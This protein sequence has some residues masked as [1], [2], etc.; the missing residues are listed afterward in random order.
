[1]ISSLSDSIARLRS[2]TQ[3]SVQPLWHWCQADLSL[4]EARSGWMDWA[5]APLND[6]DHVAWARG[7][8]M[9]WL[10]Q[11]IIIPTTLQ[12][13]S[14]EGFELR[15]SLTWW[16]ESAR[17]FVDGELVQEGDL[18]DHS[19][20]VLLSRSVQPGEA[21]E[22]LIQLVSPGHDDGALVKALCVYE[23]VDEAGDFCPEPGFVADELAVL[24]EY[25]G[26]LLPERPLAGISKSAGELAE[27]VA[28]I[29]W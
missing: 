29:D 4:E 20:R 15:L 7:R 21:I 6:R 11:R 16:A 24:Q 19:A 25:V 22:V 23:R 27:C 18:F 3:V 2:L 8:K 5:I 12:G 10:G 13:Y 1:M 14:I 28:G 26:R 9:L 17:I